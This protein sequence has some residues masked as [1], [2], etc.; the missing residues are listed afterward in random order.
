MI[1]ILYITN[2]LKYN[3]DK[4]GGRALNKAETVNRA[5]L[6]I[7]CPEKPGIISTLTDFLLAHKA[8]IVHFDQYTTDPRAGVFFVRIEFDLE[9]FDSSFEKLEQDLHV[10][11]ENY[12]LDWRLSNNLKRKRMA[13][14]VSKTDH[15]LWELIW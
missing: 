1:S 8:N 7:S 4:N 10:L 6:L 13:I 3:K 14:F 11:A 12:T 15:C 9:D 2:F 5:R